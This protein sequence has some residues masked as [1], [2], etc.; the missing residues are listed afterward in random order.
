M[1]KQGNPERNQTEFHPLGKVKRCPKSG[2]TESSLTRNGSTKCETKGKGSAR[3]KLTLRPQI[4]PFI[5]G[6][7]SYGISTAAGGNLACKGGKEK[8]RKGD[9]S[10]RTNHY[11]VTFQNS[12]GF[13]KEKV[14][15]WRKEKKSCGGKAMTSAKPHD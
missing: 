15:L 14:K 10:P 13:E 6:H 5:T 4:G 12:K 11:S 8:S 1:E 7:S 2:K 9:F 3:K